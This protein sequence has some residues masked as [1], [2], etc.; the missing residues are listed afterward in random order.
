MKK[1]IIACLGAFI[2]G[3]SISYGATY[4]SPMPVST[5]SFDTDVLEHY[6][7]DVEGINVHFDINK[8]GKVENVELQGSTGDWAVDTAIVEAVSTWRYVPAT[9][10]AGN[11]VEASK[12]E[13]ID[14]DV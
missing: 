12:T 14:L 11:P 2:L 3:T 5:P 7:G 13:Y 8:D 6:N 9:D 10:S 1:L 4:Q